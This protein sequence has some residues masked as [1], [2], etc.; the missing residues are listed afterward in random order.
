MRD[1]L[2]RLGLIKP[3]HRK[4]FDIKIENGFDSRVHRH[5]H[6]RGVSKVHGE[7]I[8]GAHQ[9][10]RYEANTDPLVSDFLRDLKNHFHLMSAPS[11]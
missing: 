10:F 2:K 1:G 9:Y 7:I 11:A 8:I 6:K 5:M 4:I 3:I